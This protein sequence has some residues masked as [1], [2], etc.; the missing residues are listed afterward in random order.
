MESRNVETYRAGHEAFNRRDFGAMVKEYAESIRW[1][2]HA[3]GITFRTP[4]EF[5]DDFLEG[6]IQA[7]SDCRVTD[8][9]YTD[10]GDTVVARLLAGV[11]TTGHSDPSRPPARSGRCRSAR[12]GTSTPTVESWEARSTTTRSRCSRS[13]SCCRSH[14]ERERRRSRPR[15][16][17]NRTADDG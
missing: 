7:S 3:R 11:R 2:D 5:K 17:T 10:A 4:Q 8:A 1:T 6:W 9:R 13:S 14:P 12:C 16:Y 15:R